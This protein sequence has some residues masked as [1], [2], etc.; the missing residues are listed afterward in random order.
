[1]K[2]IDL[3]VQILPLKNS[4]FYFKLIVLPIM[5]EKN[6]YCFTI[7]NKHKLNIYNYIDKN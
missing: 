1:M 5:W 7:K 2:V 6:L 4:A 3:N